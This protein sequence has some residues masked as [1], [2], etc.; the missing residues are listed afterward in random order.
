MPAPLLAVL[1][2]LY[3][4]YFLS[5][6]WFQLVSK[7]ILTSLFLF[8]PL[9]V[10]ECVVWLACYPWIFLC[11]FKKRKRL[12]GFKGWLTREKERSRERCCIHWL[13]ELGLSQAEGRSLPCECRKSKVLSH[14]HCFLKYTSKRLDRKWSSQGLNQHPKEMLVLQVAALLMPPCQ[15]HVVFIVV[16]SSFSPLKLEGTLYVLPSLIC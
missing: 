9:V 14:L 12:I 5:L 10:K 11:L 15:P 3:L 1:L 2:S 16:F 7:Y 4:P 6:F 13:Y 8:Y